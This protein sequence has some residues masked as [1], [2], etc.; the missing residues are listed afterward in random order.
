MPGVRAIGGGVTIAW[1]SRW[2]KCDDSGSVVAR[3]FFVMGLWRLIC[4]SKIGACAWLVGHHARPGS[5]VPA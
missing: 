1:E 3:L 5:F 4:S 2:G